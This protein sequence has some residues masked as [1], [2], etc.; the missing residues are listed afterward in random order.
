MVN[1]KNN[2]SSQ[3]TQRRLLEA[4]GEV[5]AEHGFHCATIKEITRR[6]GASLASVNYHFHDKAELYASVI[7]RFGA[8]MDEI[9]PPADRLA[10]QPTPAARLKYFVEYAITRI[11]GR[12]Q[13][14]WER[15]L[16]TRA[17][18]MPGMAPDMRS[19]IQEAF[20]PFNDQ[21]LQLIG[22]AIGKSQ[23]DLQVNLI[24]AS[25]IGQFVFYCH[26]RDLLGVVH[27]KNCPLPTTPQIAAH[28]A[29]FTLRAI[30]DHL[31][32]TD[33]AAQGT[34][35]SQESLTAAPAKP[36]RRKPATAPKRRPTS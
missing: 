27:F 30:R 18:W 29:D 17:F 14:A 15:V 3:E 21:L 16:L 34:A 36:R 7:R 2:C 5:F 13:P 24:A 11:L 32:L 19:V 35:E 9:L 23:D 22:Q 26:H 12:Q 8:D 20:R 33:E 31:A 25:V 6:A 1:V 4:A 10:E 28:I